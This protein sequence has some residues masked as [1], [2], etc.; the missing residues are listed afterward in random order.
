MV[1]LFLDAVLAVETMTGNVDITPVSVTNMGIVND[2]ADN[3]FY[4]CDISVRAKE[5]V[6]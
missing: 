2:P 4:G 6:N 3:V 1:A 5:F